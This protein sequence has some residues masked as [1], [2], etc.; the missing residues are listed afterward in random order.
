MSGFFGWSWMTTMASLRLQPARKTAR[1]RLRIRIL[2]M[3]KT[4]PYG[5]LKK[6]V[7]RGRSE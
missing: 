1:R 3:H 2:A 5:M 6:V 7:Q 4:K